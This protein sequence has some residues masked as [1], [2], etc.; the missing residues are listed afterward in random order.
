M[1]GIMFFNLTFTQV[2][3]QQ[4]QQSAWNTTQ[5]QLRNLF[6]PLQRPTPSK[7]FLY[8]MSAHL[9]DST[10]FTQNPNKPHNADNWF[11]LYEEMQAMAYN[12][13]TMPISDSI[14]AKAM[15]FDGDTVPIGIMH[16]DPLCFK[17]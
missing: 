3:A 7:L 15:R 9:V 12:T 8:D 5:I 14:F 13:T 1:M 4:T 16:Y 6:T 10:F 2:Y 11:M 17:T